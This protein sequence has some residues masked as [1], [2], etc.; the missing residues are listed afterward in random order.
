MFKGLYSAAASMVVQQM[1][2]NVSAN[3]LANV[4]KT[5]FKREQITTQTFQELLMLNITKD[6][7][8]GKLGSLTN[9]VELKG[10][11][12]DFSKGILQNTNRTMDVALESD[13][14]FVVNT[15]QGEGYTRDGSFQ[16]DNQGRLQ[17]NE[18]FSV[19]G[20]YG[21]IFLPV[22]EDFS[23]DLLEINEKGEIY[24]DGEYIDTLVVVNMGGNIEKYS[25]TIFKGENVNESE[26]FQ[27]RQGALENSNVNA[28]KEMVK[29]VETMRSYEANQKVIQAYDSSLEKAVN[30]V[31]RL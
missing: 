12:T 17:T 14:Y 13:G 1:N 16:V 6:R 25:S 2:H 22:G 30:E 4:N 29:L 20:Q 11:N 15:L 31:G 28:I 27:I 24:F 8:K 26:D 9:G 3:N 7:E 19:L 5:G 10:I 21:E 18:G 23:E